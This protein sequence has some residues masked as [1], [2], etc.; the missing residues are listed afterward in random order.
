MKWLKIVVFF[1]ALCLLFSTTGSCQTAVTSLRGIVNDPSGAVIPGAKVTIAETQNGYKAERIANEHGEFA[2]DQISPGHYTVEVQATGFGGEKTLI[3]LLVNQPRTLNFKLSVSTSVATVEVDA[4]DVL[5]NMSDATVGTPFN[6][7]QIQSLPFEGNNVLD[8]LSL[9]AGVLFLGDAKPGAQDADSRSGSVNGARSDQSNLT[10][11]GLDNN[12]Q[13]RGYAFS[14]VLRSTRDSVEEFRVVTTNANADSGR[15]SGAQISL[16]TRSG[17]NALHGSLYEYNRPTDT[18]ANDWFNKQAQAESDEQ[19]RPGKYL[20]NTY[21][22]T[23]GGPIV[24]DKLFFFTTYEGQKIA[25]SKQVTRNVPLASFLAGNLT[26][27]NASGTTTTLGTSDLAAIDPKCSANGSCPLG[28]GVNSAVIQYLS[29]L[30]ASNGNNG[31]DGYNIGSYT[32]SSHAPESLITYIV[33]MDYNPNSKHT[34]FVRG[35]LQQ[36]NIVAEAQFPGSLPN[37]QTYDNSKGIAA[38]DIWYMSN[39]M[40]NN[41]RYGFIRQGYSNRGS[42]T[43]DFVTFGG[44]D[45]LASTQDTSAIVSIPVHNVVDDLTWTKGAHTFQFGGNYRFITDNRQVDATL[46]KQANVTPYFLTIGSIAGQGTSL[47]PGAFG[48]AP[49]GQNF[50]TAYNH[51]IAD[52]TGLITHASEYFNYKVTGSSLTPLPAG[53]WTKRNFVASEA[54]FYGQ[55]SWKIKPNLTLTFGLRYGLLQAPYESH[56]QQVVPT[57]N[58]GKWFDNRVTGAAQGQTVQPNIAFMQ[59]GKA[60]N[61]PGLWSMD[62]LDLAPRFAVAWS[63]ITKASIRAGWGLYYDHFGQG[64]INSFDSQGSFGLS[65]NAANGVDQDVNT[66]PRF[67]SETSVPTSIIPA[68]SSSGTFPTTP[69]AIQALTW[70]IDGSLKTPYSHVIDFSVQYELPKGNSLEVA[71]TGRLG[72]RLLQMRDIATPLDLTDP[73]SGTDYFAAATQLSKY[74]DAGATIDQVT[75]NP[76]WENMFPNAAGNGHTATQNIYNDQFKAFRGNETAALY[77]LDLGYYGNT[78]VNQQFRYFDPQYASLYVWSSV[79]TSSYHA[80]QASFH[81]PMSRGL[82]ADFYYTLSKS[83]DLGSDA[84]RL[85]PNSSSVGGKSFS[86]IINVYNIKG[87]RGVSDFNTT[88]AVTGNLLALLPFGHGAM[89][90]SN[91]NTLVD[92]LIGHWSLTGLT[93]WTSGLPFSTIDGLGWGTDWA[94]NSFDVSTSKIATGGH[95]NVFKSQAAALANIRAPYPGEAGERNNLNGMGYFSVDTGLTKVFKIAEKQDLKFA[96]EAFNV[97]NSVRFDPHSI[98]NDPFG[99]PTAFGQYTA[100]LTQERRMQFSLRYGF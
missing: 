40:V 97:T 64:V 2:F 89:F 71:Y 24:K 93:H 94:D 6:N 85:A 19:N 9:Q 4:S 1:P 80:M 61:E 54:E 76:Y 68:I 29:Q 23:F 37:T 44:I 70:G 8:L 15:S 88:H 18:V 59:G 100:L 39:S 41:I 12:D 38:G 27:V 77:D 50:Y 83:I 69:P 57:F 45:T 72:R 78:P 22:V 96:A 20:R 5:M 47:D 42:T 21:G 81:H 25:E 46:Y 48:Y 32:F 95:T 34:I 3:E 31:G 86:Q 17:T 67:S 79:G 53:Q 7:Q 90:L 63:P 49:V 60:N 82:S 10:L 51:A 55:D 58:L 92:E 98:V 75:T 35:N 16:V 14:G 28:P 36:D 43:S 99:S 13:G 87:N 91:A 30:P 56:G 52:I 74:V 26:Y 65:S 62:K 73:K 84:E 11:D 33:K 66:A